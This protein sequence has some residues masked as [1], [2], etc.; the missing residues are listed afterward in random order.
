MI[1][2]RGNELVGVGF[3]YLFGY[4]IDEFE[5]VIAGRPR[6]ESIFYITRFS[7]CENSLTL[8]AFAPMVGVLRYDGK[9]ISDGQLSAF[10]ALSVEV[11]AC[12][13]NDLIDNVWIGHAK[14]TP[15][16]LVL[17]TECEKIRSRT[18][19]QFGAL[20]ILEEKSI[21]KTCE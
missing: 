11:I 14:L 6:A 15:E 4:G 7:F 21:P 8:R 2:Q 5:N 9:I 19:E 3:L 20:G 17:P 10:E 1:G 16:T 13:P 18:F 12:V